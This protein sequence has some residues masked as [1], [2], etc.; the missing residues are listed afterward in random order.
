MRFTKGYATMAVASSAR[1]VPVD[2]FFML[3][4]PGWGDGDEVLRIDES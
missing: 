3:S 1:P 2:R 4:A